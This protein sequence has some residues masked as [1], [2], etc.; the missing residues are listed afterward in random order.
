[1]EVTEV[2]IRRTFDVGPMKA[3]V[4]VTF[5]GELAVHDVKIVSS[6]GK[7]FVVMPAKKNPSGGFRDIVHPI[8]PAA[9]AAIETAVLSAYEEHMNTVR[10]TTE[11]P[12]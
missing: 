10:E 9:R 4:S 2:R 5:D 7:T 8:N 3:V 6:G 11:L 1:M 12:I